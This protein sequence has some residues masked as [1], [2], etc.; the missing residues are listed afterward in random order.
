MTAWRLADARRRVEAVQTEHPELTNHG[1][2]LWNQRR[3]TLTEV[4]QQMADGR[5]AMLRPFEL[6]EF[7][8]AI[9][10]LRDKPRTKYPNRGAGTT[11][12]LKHKAERGSGYISNGMLI[13]AVLDLGFKVKRIA[14]SPECFINIARIRP[15]DGQYREREPSLAEVFPLDFGS[16]S[17]DPWLVAP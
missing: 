5:A 4:A 11:Y 3:L 14:H 17:A 10:W 13:A 16:L 1:F 8:R 2:G 12:G 6:G 7:S 9:D 15:T